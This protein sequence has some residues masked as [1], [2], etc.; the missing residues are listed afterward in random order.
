MDACLCAYAGYDHYVSFGKWLST[1][2]FTSGHSWYLA[3]TI[4]IFMCLNAPHGR[5]KALPTFAEALLHT[6]SLSM[7]QNSSAMFVA[8]ESLN[9]KRVSFQSA[10]ISGRNPQQMQQ[11][12]NIGDG[13]LLITVW[14]SPRG[15]RIHYSNTIHT[16]CAHFSKTQFPPWLIYI[17]IG[18]KF[19]FFILQI[20]CKHQVV[21]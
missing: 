19:R 21:C 13:F 14:E 16:K 6:H 2:N 20:K 17:R 4:C 1:I 15:G 11:Q 5:R 18:S 12:I 8:L 9:M 10:P 7:S 3:N